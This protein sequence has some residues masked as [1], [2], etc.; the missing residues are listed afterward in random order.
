MSETPITQLESTMS[1][2]YQQ[3]DLGRALQASLAILQQSPDHHAAHLITAK[4]RQAQGLYGLARNHAE[5]S[6]KSNPLD[7]ESIKTA[8]RAYGALGESEK[9]I[10]MCQKILAHNPNDLNTLALLASFLERKGDTSAAL[11]VIQ[12][13]GS[14]E[15]NALFGLTQAKCHLTQGNHKEALG[16]LDRSIGDIDLG[17]DQNRSKVKRRLLLQ[18]AQV[19]DAMQQ[20]DAAFQDATEGKSLDSTPFDAEQFSQNIDKIIDCFSN[21]QF[22]KSHR[23]NPSQ[24][25]H[26]FIVGMPRSGTTLVEQILDAHPDC[27]GVGEFKSLHVL[28]TRLHQIIGSWSNWPASAKGMSL[29]NRQRFSTAYESDLKNHGYEDG[30]CFVNKSLMNMRLLG[31]VAMLIPNAKVIYTHRNARDIAVSCMLGNFAANVHPELQSLSGISTLLEQ[32]KKLRNHW[33]TV[34]PVETLDVNYEDLVGDQESV[35]RKIVNF[36][37]LEWSDKCLDFYNTGRTV[38][39]LSYDQ[40]NR[41]VYKSSV[42]RFENYASH[43]EGYNWTETTQS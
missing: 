18:R 26:V 23:P 42:N 22:Q 25:E 30:M 33:D 35:T 7:I 19:N 8:A 11:E 14:A 10:A 40:V 2:A 4:I 13:S 24:K 20:F 9:A 3:G 36:C 6:H 28:S 29:Q 37:G 43:L 27:T 39:T 32:H 5:A 21:D 1:A 17:I 41:P 16:V 12:K 38:M 31:L 34:L 15:K